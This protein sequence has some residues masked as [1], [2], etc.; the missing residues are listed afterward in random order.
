[1]KDQPLDVVVGQEQD[2]KL[3][4]PIGSERR[5]Q[6]TITISG[7]DAAVRIHVGGL[8]Y[9]IDEIYS[10]GGLGIRVVPAVD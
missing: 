2:V 10:D 4:F 3:H 8:T 5:E 1:M 9:I 6:A 7:S